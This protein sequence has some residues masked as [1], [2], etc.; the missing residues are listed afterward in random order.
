MPIASGRL[1]VESVLGSCGTT[2]PH[3]TPRRVR[4]GFTGPPSCCGSWI[5]PE[6]CLGSKHWFSIKARWVQ[7]RSP[8]AYQ[9]L[10]LRCKTLCRTASVRGFTELPARPDKNSTRKAS[11]S[12]LAA[13]PGQEPARPASRDGG[14]RKTHQ[15]DAERCGGCRP[16]AADWQSAPDVVLPPAGRDRVGNAARPGVANG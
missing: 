13:L 9:S 2:Q 4:I 5:V 11:P 16:L 7:D 10:H 3:K 8:T 6:R 15:T 1:L 12:I 14:C